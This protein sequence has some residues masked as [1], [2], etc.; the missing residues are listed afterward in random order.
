MKTYLTGSIL[1]LVRLRSTASQSQQG[2]TSNHKSQRK[3][4]QIFQNL[5]KKRKK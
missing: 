3:P 2:K 1:I 4:N 5:E